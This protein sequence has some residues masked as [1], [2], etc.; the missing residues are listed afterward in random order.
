[1]SLNVQEM[2]KG[3]EDSRRNLPWICS[4]GHGKLCLDNSQNFS[5]NWPNS[6]SQCTKVMKKKTKKFFINLLEL[7]RKLQFRQHCRKL[8]QDSGKFPL[9]SDKCCKDCFLQNFFPYNSYELVES[10]FTSPLKN[11][12]KMPNCIFSL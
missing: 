8:Q 7:T 9:K 4:F 11:S 3:H 1:M 2:K 6:F 12:N 5:R 10:S